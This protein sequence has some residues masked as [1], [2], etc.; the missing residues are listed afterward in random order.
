MSGQFF[1]D[2]PALAL[3]LLDAFLLCW[4]G[5]TILLEAD[6]RSVGVWLSADGLFLGAVFFIAHT[7]ILRNGVPWNNPLVNFWWRAGWWPLILSPFAW[8]CVILWYSGYWDDATSQ[9]HR[10]QAPWFGLMLVSTAG[11]LGWMLLADPLPDLGSRSASISEFAGLAILFPIYIFLCVLLALNAILRPGPTSRLVGHEARRYARPWLTASTLILLFVCLLVAFALVWGLRTYESEYQWNTLT[12]QVF[13]PL[14]GLDILIEILITIAILLIGQAAMVYEVFSSI[15]LPRSSLRKRWIFAIRSGSLFAFVFSAVLIFFARPEAAYLIFIPFLAGALTL[16]NRFSAREQEQGIDQLRALTS[17][18]Q[19]YEK[20]FLNPSASASKADILADFKM[21]CQHVVR[22]N[23]AL[24]V[25]A[26][27][28][29]NFLPE[30]IRFPEDSIVPSEPV[31]DFDRLENRD[32]PRSLN[33]QKSNGFCW[34]IPLVSSRGVDGWLYI[35][36]RTGGGF[37]TQEEI[38][39]TRAAIERWMDNQ[40]AAE[41]ARRLVNLQQQKLIETRLLD[42][43]ARRVLHDEVL[44]LLHT[45]LLA[46]PQSEVSDQI[47]AAHRQISRLLRNAPSPPPVDIAQNGLIS[48]IRKTA[49]NEAALLHANLVFEADPQIDRIT[50]ALSPE[51]AETVYYAVRECLRNIEK[52]N[53]SNETQ[54]LEITIRIVVDG[55]LQITIENTG[56]A[57]E[58]SRDFRLTTTGQGL[59]LHNALLAVFGGGIRLTRRENGST[60]VTLTLPVIDQIS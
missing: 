38:E 15:P 34:A 25:P 53:Q 30:N 52:H 45:A 19:N 13:V 11:L 27:V 2:W 3:S 9:L 7:A 31:V 32:Q 41:I 57:D 29:T 18:Q 35:G 12:Y 58:T 6:R 10:R 4:L 59:L 33:P 28:L 60:L 51:A 24:V 8:Y 5:F 47:S 21:I 1:L 55:M 50:A 36:D 39:I 37:Y 26:G 49:Q 42:Q 14:T 44:P 43:K 20:I 56:T 48:V 23:Q 16:Q 22:T 17:P 46:N 40:A 54:P